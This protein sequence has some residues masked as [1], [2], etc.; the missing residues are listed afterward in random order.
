MNIECRAFFS[1]E[2]IAEPLCSG[3]QIAQQRAKRGGWGCAG[4][5]PCGDAFQP[6]Q[7]HH[8]E[9][10]GA[11]NTFGPVFQI[12]Q[13]LTNGLRHRDQARFIAARRDGFNAG[14]AQARIRKWARGRRWRR[15]G[16]C[17]FRDF[18]IEQPRA[19]PG[20]KREKQPNNRA[21]PSAKPGREARRHPHQ[22]GGAL[23]IPAPAAF[24]DSRGNEGQTNPE[25]AAN[26]GLLT[27]GEKIEDCRRHQREPRHGQQPQPPEAVHRPNT[28]ATARHSAS[29]PARAM[30]PLS[31]M[32]P[33]ERFKPS[34]RLGVGGAAR[35]AL[36]FWLTRRYIAFV[37]RAIKTG[38]GGSWAMEQI[39]IIGTGLIGRAWAMVFAR[40][41][42]SVRIWDPVVG[43]SEAALG[44]IGQS[45]QDLADAG[46][47]TEAPAVIAARISAAA[48]MEDCVAGAAHVQE[49]GPE[50]VEPKRAL[51][52]QLDALCGPDVVLASSTS[53]IPASAFTE[54]LA[55]RARCLVAHPVNPPYLVPLVELVGAPWTAPEVVA[56]TRALMARVGQVPV[57]AMKETRG[58]V[59]NRLQAALVAEAFRLVRD[60]VMSV[61][62][63]DACVKDGLGL[64]WSFMGPFETIDLN[65]PGG[66]ADYAA[67]FGGLM[68]GITEEQ[69]PFLYDETTVA[70]VTAERRAAL[71]LEKI[72]ARS[73]WRD[74]RLMGVLAHKKKARE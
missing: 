14:K 39:A 7:M 52:A 4:F 5:K 73:A 62:D 26:Q 13:H 47:I 21:C 19:A 66:V 67:R 68:G 61:E 56:R 64:R 28:E 15:R 1:T 12:I 2:I 37:P 59:L 11:G 72:G 65:A 46:L 30:V 16:R 45:L 74:R 43:V 44:L 6:I 40:A 17:G 20:A 49:N 58:F 53:G 10:A 22:H 18:A 42:H 36:R 27:H 54:G 34:G 35:G 32:K 31:S 70:R 48:S 60:G 24:H 63:V 71:P 50:R 69:T 9:A 57:T 23:G 25:Q 55:G 33:S 3:L 8:Q 41:G 38:K 29:M 51:F